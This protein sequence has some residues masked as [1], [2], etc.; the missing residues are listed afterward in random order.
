MLDFVNYNNTDIESNLLVD[1]N[2]PGLMSKED[3]KK[4]N[5]LP[6]VW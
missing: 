4:L 5:G 6:G 2:S 3:K 1:N